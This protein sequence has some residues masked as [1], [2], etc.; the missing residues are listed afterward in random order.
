MKYF[1]CLT[2]HLVNEIMD[3]ELYDEKLTFYTLPDVTA[4]ITK[5][6]NVYM[7]LV[8]AFNVIF[9]IQNNP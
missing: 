5:K 4:I 3:Q 9:L 1:K 7:N 8:L 6:N 2:F